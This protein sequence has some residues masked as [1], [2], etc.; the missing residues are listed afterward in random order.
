MVHQTSHSLIV[1]E[2]QSGTGKDSSR[3]LGAGA[4]LVF[5]VQV[6]DEHLEAILPELIRMIPAGHAV[7]CESGWARNLVEPGLFL[8]LHRKGNAEIKESAGK[9]RGL[10]HAWIEFDGQDFDFQLERISFDSGWILGPV[11]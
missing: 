1:R 11:Q 4:D 8:I 10:S 6:W 2:E 5:Y 9:L 7:V 3:M